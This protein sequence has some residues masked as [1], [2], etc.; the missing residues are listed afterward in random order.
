MERKVPEQ[1]T[2]NAI[3]RFSWAQASA[4]G[5]GDNRALA[6]PLP[7]YH[8]NMA[9]QN[10]SPFEG[11]SQEVLRDPPE[12]RIAEANAI[13]VAEALSLAQQMGVPI[14]KSTLQRWA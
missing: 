12:I 10:T 11:L 13:T 7:C 1:R 4:L 8:A 9:H 14:G 3:L 6:G 5:Y 2:I